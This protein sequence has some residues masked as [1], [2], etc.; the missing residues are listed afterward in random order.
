MKPHLGL[1]LIL[2]AGCGDDT[3]TMEMDMAPAVPRCDDGRKNGVETDVDCGGGLCLRCEDGKSCAVGGDCVS[4]ICPQ[5]VCLPM[6]CANGAL[7]GSESDID[8]GGG[9]CAKC[10]FNRKCKA[11]GDC[12]SNLCEKGLC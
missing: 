1:M 10:E 3:A 9:V 12:T 11:N 6:S 2:V 5:F 4:G 7:D 8:C